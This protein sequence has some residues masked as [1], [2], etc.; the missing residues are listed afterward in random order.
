MQEQAGWGLVPRGRGGRGATRTVLSSQLKTVQVPGT[1]QTPHGEHSCPRN[2]T[3]L[4]NCL[5]QGLPMPM[6]GTVT[7]EWLKKRK[8]EKCRKKRKKCAKE[9][10]KKER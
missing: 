6:R 3:L 7:F 9:G 4:P 8:Q 10:F 5:Q 2:Q 1:I